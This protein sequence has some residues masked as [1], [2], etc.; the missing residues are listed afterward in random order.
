MGMENVAMRS[1]QGAGCKRHNGFTLIELLVVVAIIA[2]LVSI[3]LPSLK[4]AKDLTRNAVCQ[5]HL[6]QAGK[7]M[8]LYAI[9]WDDYLPGPNSSGYFIREKIMGI[10]GRIPQGFFDGDTTPVQHDDWMSPIFGEVIGLS[11]KRTDRV[12]TLF[13]HEFR[14]PANSFNYLE[15]YNG[16]YTDDWPDASQ[17]SLNSYSAPITLHAFQDYDHARA[18]GRPYGYV[19]PSHEAACID[20]TTSKY[21][22]TLSSIGNPS[23]KVACMDGSRYMKLSPDG[24]VLD[25]EADP[26]VVAWPTTF[27]NFSPGVNAH[28]PGS[29][30]P[31]KYVGAGRARKDY[32]LDEQAEKYSYRHPKNTINAAFLDAHVEQLNNEQ[33][34][35]ASLWLP[36]GATILNPFGSGGDMIADWSVTTWHRID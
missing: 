32:T 26:T 31:Y 20:L 36:K 11:R 2:L 4:L 14:C 16:S 22:G 23:E 17:I 9:E 15:V 13:N 3:L 6:A 21:R 12:V 35:K 19:L 1:M 28:Y 29:G 8:G 33:S 27:M 5:A 7:H 25:F 18:M 10:G 30:H 24:E 34:R